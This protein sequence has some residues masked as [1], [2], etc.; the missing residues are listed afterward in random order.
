MRA[1][2]TEGRYTS[3]PMKSRSG[4]AAARVARTSPDP[5]PISR[6]S[7]AVRPKIRDRSRWASGATDVLVASRGT[8]IMYVLARVSMARC[9]ETFMRG[10]RRTKDTTP[11]RTRSPERC[12]PAEW[13][14]EYSA[15]LGSGVGEPHPEAASR[16]SVMSTHARRWC[17]Q[18]AST[19]FR[20]PVVRN[21]MCLRKRDHL[22][23]RKSI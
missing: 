12:A 4:W 9:W 8:S 2:A 20:N 16:S 23:I 14:S 13:S 6:V 10:D 15:V 3:N 22:G 1:L 17:R 21:S 19:S 18:C 7:G 5:A 11:R